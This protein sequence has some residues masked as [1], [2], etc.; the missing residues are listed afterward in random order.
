MAV[1][2]IG[3]DEEDA[4]IFKSIKKTTKLYIMVK[5]DFIDYLNFY[6]GCGS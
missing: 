6:V 4:P 1:K 3:L 2:L 5:Q